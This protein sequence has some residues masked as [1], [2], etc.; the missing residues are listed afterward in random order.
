MQHRAR[1]YALI[2][3]GRSVANFVGPLISGVSIDLIGHRH[4]FR[5]L[6]FFVA[7]PTAAVGLYKTLRGISHIVIP[8]FFGSVGAAFGFKTVF[9]SNSGLPAF[10]GLLQRQNKG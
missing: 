3:M 10:G 7:V 9:L 5:V 8:I 4:V 1:N 2:A 6:A